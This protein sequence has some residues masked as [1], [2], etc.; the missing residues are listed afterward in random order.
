MAQAIEASTTS[1][2]H[3]FSNAQLADAL[4]HADAALKGAEAECKALWSSSVD[5]VE[6]AGA[7]DD[8]PIDD[9]ELEG[10]DDGKDPDSEPSLGAGDGV[11]QERA[12]SLRQNPT[13]DDCEQQDED[14]DE[15]DRPE[16]GD[17]D[18]FGEADGDSGGIATTDD[19]EE[20]NEDGDE[21]DKLQCADLDISGEAD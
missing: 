13:T 21:L 8:H 17:E 1:R 4:G 5:D 11:N 7:D 15:L 12:W 14:G 2:F 16:G 20:Q 18:V 6:A 3:N 10:G 9:N 19:C